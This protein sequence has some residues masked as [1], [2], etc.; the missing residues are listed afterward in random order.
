MKKSTKMSKRWLGAT[1]A[2]IAL[3]CVRPAVAQIGNVSVTDARADIAGQIRGDIERYVRSI[4]EASAQL[5]S[6]VWLQSPASS[7]INPGGEARGWQQIKDDFYLTV[8]GKTYSKRALNLDGEPRIEIFG[9][10]AVA[11]FN[12]DFVATRRDNGRQVH[13]MGR[14]S[15]VYVR[16]TNGRWVLV[17][18]H[19]SGRPARDAAPP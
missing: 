14:E 8:M 13:R 7:L 10:A 12:W 11:E 3:V 18:V 1:L 4:D 19:Y 16:R 6:T 15:Q 17:H 9:C 5:A 2:A